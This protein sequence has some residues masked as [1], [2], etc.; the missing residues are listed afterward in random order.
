MILFPLGALGISVRA[1]F[2]ITSGLP[3]RLSPDISL[4]LSKVERPLYCHFPGY[5]VRILQVLLQILLLQRFLI[6]LPPL[7]IH[8][9]S[10]DSFSLAS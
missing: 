8:G 1:R 7:L 4:S 3:V 2:W 6:I 10:A 5:F 9:R